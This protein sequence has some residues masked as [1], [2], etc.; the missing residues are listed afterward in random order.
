MAA[1]VKIASYSASRSVV[2]EFSTRIMRGAAAGIRISMDG[3]P[4]D[5]S[6]T[7]LEVAMSTL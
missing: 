6:G 2:R 1:A 5:D 3:G 7:Q 4:I